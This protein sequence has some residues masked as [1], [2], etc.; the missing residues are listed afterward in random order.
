MYSDFAEKAM[1]VRQL[2]GFFEGGHIGH[3]SGTRNDL[4][5]EGLYDCTVDFST[6]PEVIGVHY[7]LPRSIRFKHLTL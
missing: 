6:P 2:A 7:D 3:Q 5:I 1:A 4:F